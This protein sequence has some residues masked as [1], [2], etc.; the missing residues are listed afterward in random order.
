MKDP[1][2][3]SQQIRKHC[4]KNLGTSVLNSPMSPPSL[5][6]KGDGEGHHLPCK[7]NPPRT[8]N[9]PLEN[10]G[11]WLEKIYKHLPDQVP[12]YS[13][14]AQLLAPNGCGTVILL[15]GTGC[16]TV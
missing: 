1:R 5:K 3:L 7:R 9:G 6:N 14:S 13:S 12:Q 4:Q 2:F 15:A 11:G 16:F 8:K 10:L